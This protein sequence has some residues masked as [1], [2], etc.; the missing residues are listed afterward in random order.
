VTWTVRVQLQ[1]VRSAYTNTPLAYVSGS[2]SANR[3][4]S[5]CVH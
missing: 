3:Q 2:Y 5:S 1:T 4:S